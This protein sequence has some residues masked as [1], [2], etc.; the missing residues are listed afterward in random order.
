MKKLLSIILAICVFS[1]TKTAE[2]QDL[3]SD[4]T[5]QNQSSAIAGREAAKKF[6][7]SI[8]FY[9]KFVWFNVDCRP[10]TWYCW[11]DGG[12]SDNRS[13]IQ[14]DQN[15]QKITFGIDNQDPLRAKYNSQFINKTNYNFPQDT[16]KTDLTYAITGLKDVIY[17]E[18]GSYP[19]E[20]ID[21]VVTITVPYLK[22]K[23]K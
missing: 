8:Q 16:L 14:I 7:L 23:V 13:Y 15:S 19:F 5:S 3:T 21:N 18:K 9:A 1:C 6:P 22:A 10:S 20:I 17:V 11:T 12:V 4:L 2:K